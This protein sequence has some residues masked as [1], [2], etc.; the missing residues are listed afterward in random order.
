MKNIE[1]IENTEDQENNVGDEP[2]TG[3]YLVMVTRKGVIKRTALSEYAR[4]RRGG[5]IALTLDEGDELVFVAYV[6]SPCDIIIASR[7]GYAVRFPINDR[8]L[9]P[10]GRNARGVRGILL[11]EG[12]EVVGTAIVPAGELSGG[13]N[14]E[15]N[16]ENIENNIENIS[17][18]ADG[19][20]DAD[21]VKETSGEPELI[22]ITENG[23]GKRTPFRFF[24]V[25]KN[26]GGAG[27]KCH[28]IND[29]TGLLAGIS[30]VTD[31]DD[32]FMITDSGTVIRISAADIPAYSRGAS[33]VIVM[34]LAD[35]SKIVNFTK[36]PSEPLLS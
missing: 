20:E 34:R 18:D 15:S 32:I 10:M 29:R 7:G 23:Y 12:D 19:A 26:R 22:T 16:I 2:L 36:V 21:A 31:D 35:G 27:V 5:K 1:N 4:A 30:T 24:R 28:N 9:R 14:I 6:N 3:D 33:G 13:D 17:D 11:H 8:L 25:M